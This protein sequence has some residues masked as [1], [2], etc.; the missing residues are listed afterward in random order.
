M[1]SPPLPPSVSLQAFDPHHPRVLAVLPQNQLTSNF[2]RPWFIE[3]MA[4]SRVDGP[5]LPKHQFPDP[6]LEQIFG[7][8]RPLVVAANDQ[9]R[10]LMRYSWVSHL[11]PHTRSHARART[12]ATHARARTHA[13]PHAR[14][15]RTH[16]RHARPPRTHARPPRT[17]ASL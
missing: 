16:A 7:T 15:A 3:R 10:Q 13:R 1:A 8:K 5:C 2:D 14:H 4:D 11:H 17:H 6:E 12:P 9:F